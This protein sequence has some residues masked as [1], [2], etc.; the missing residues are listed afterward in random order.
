MRPAHIHFIVS[1][2]GY[3]PV[4]TQIFDRKDKYVDNDAVFA[5]KENLV[6]DFVE[7]VGDPKATFELQYAFVLAKQG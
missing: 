7:R 4:V 1:A 2:S 5:V 6:V 3:R